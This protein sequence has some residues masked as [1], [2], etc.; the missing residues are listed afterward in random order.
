MKN[1]CKLVPRTPPEGFL[2]WC[3]EKSRT[4]DEG[5][6]PLDIHGLVFE[7]EWVE[8]EG[9]APMLEERKPR[10][11]KMVHLRCTACG[12]ERWVNWKG[13]T[14]AL[15]KP[16]Y[17]FLSIRE[18]GC[19]SVFDG[20]ETYCPACGDRVIAKKAA[21][22]GNGYHVSAT[23]YFMSALLL[24]DRALALTGWRMERRFGRSGGSYLHAQPYDAYVF[25]DKD[26][27][28]LTGWSKQYGQYSGYFKAWNP[29]WRQPQR[30][31]EGWGQETDIFGLTPELVAESQLPHC[32]LYEYM[33]GR[34]F[35]P[36]A[37]PAPIAYLRLYQAHPNVETLVTAGLPNLLDEL[38]AEEMR[39]DRWESNNRGKLALPEIHWK[40]KRPSA[41]LGLTREELRQARKQGWGQYF[42]RLYTRCL[43]HGEKL[44]EEDLRN[45]WY[46]GDE[47]LCPSSAGGRW[48]RAS[49]TSSIRRRW[50]TPGRP[51]RRTRRR[52]S[53]RA[54]RQATCWITGPWR[55]AWATTWETRTF[56]GPGISTRPTRRQAWPRRGGRTGPTTR[57]SGSATAPC[58]SGGSAGTAF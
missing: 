37:S 38:M 25:T 39:G 54:S 43:A 19:E 4:R 17:G 3:R 18:H 57:P 34:L 46:L 48:G 33:A 21:K 44:T 35:S 47:H 42:W 36:N 13:R 45:I 49:A 7:A 5:E 55:R 40:E 11:I 14:T 23:A 12:E 31:V 6:D 9:I 53:G 8:E 22:L 2:D 27:A 15:G 32:K 26:C 52:P 16:D 51:R 29:E 20:D 1:Y 41:M 10:K 58:G 50:R 30:W 28:K 24:P 56:A